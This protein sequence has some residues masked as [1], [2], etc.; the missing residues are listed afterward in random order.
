MGDSYQLIDTYG[1]DAD[2]ASQWLGV[3]PGYSTVTVT[4]PTTLDETDYTYDVVNFAGVTQAAGGRIEVLNTKS[5]FGSDQT[6]MTTLLAG[7]FTTV[8]AAP[9]FN[10]NGTPGNTGGDVNYSLGELGPLFPEYV[11]TQPPSEWGV[12][13][14]YV[15]ELNDSDIAAFYDISHYGDATGVISI[16]GFENTNVKLGT[17]APTG[18]GPGAGTMV[19]VGVDDISQGYFDM[20][21]APGK[22]TTILETA[23]PSTGNQGTTIVYKSSPY[24]GA[25]LVT[26]GD[27]TGAYFSNG[28][29]FD[30]TGAKQ[31]LV[32]TETGA[33]D[34]VNLTASAI[35]ADINLTNGGTLIGASAWSAMVSGK[36]TI[37]SLEAEIG[38][39]SGSGA[40]VNLNAAFDHYTVRVAGGTGLSVITGFGDSTA[41]SLTIAQSA[42]FVGEQSYT[43]ATGTTAYGYFGSNGGGAVLIGSAAQLSRES[44]GYTSP[45]NERTIQFIGA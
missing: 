7:G 2:T 5:G 14:N 30:D 37:A 6:D 27:M 40:L 26:D 25:V 28:S 42:S 34:T 18:T 12:V 10:W 43:D 33:G 3:Q 36:R 31:I 16:N 41:F 38:T 24:G 13:Q 21:Q 35:G 20:S 8:T 17:T 1:A 15:L 4:V 44:P 22:V 32:F 39:G 9:E 29:T 19:N 23:T 45:G 11:V